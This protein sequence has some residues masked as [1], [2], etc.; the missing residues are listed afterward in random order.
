MEGEQAA[1]I[2]PHQ[3]ALKSPVKKKKKNRMWQLSFSFER[4]CVE[5]LHAGRRSPPLPPPTF[6]TFASFGHFSLPS[7]NGV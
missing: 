5:S 1:S 7:L 4:R 6:L 2:S 3:A